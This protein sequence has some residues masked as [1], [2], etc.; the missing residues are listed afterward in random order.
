MH[1]VLI[2]TLFLKEFSLLK[3]QGNTS[4]SLYIIWLRLAL[5]IWIFFTFTLFSTTNHWVYLRAGTIM[6]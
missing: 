2:S 6:L 4:F 3:F 5:W 1:R